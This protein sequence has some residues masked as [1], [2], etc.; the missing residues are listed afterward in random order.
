M[1][2]DH[3]HRH[4]MIEVDSGRDLTLRRVRDPMKL[5]A[6]IREVMTTPMVRIA[7][8]EPVLVEGWNE[9]KARKG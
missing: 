7:P 8:Q 2:K 1:G 6:M 4:I 5:S 9:R 3:Q